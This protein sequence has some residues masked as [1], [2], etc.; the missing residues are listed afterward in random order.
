MGRLR[1]TKLNVCGRGSA[2]Y[3]EWL[4]EGFVKLSRGFAE[5]FGMLR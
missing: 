3:A 5:G 2:S 1:Q 4:T